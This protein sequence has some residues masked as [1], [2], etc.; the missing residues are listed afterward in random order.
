M[1]NTGTRYPHI[2]TIDKS[3]VINEDYIVHENER[4]VITGEHTKVL[5]GGEK[6]IRFVN[7]GCVEIYAKVILGNCLLFQ[8]STSLLIDGMLEI[9]DGSSIIIGDS[10][11]AAVENSGMIIVSG[12]AKIIGGAEFEST[13]TNTGIIQLLNKAS[14]IAG[15]K[16]VCQLRNTGIIQ[17]SCTAVF[18]TTQISSNTFTNRGL[19]QIIP[20]L[21]I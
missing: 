4:L 20:E 14:F 12:R 9:T 2:I 5:F 19:I 1:E 16:A 18:D 11:K 8:N 10:A 13:I 17:K 6:A 21:D 15:Q 3:T 7:L